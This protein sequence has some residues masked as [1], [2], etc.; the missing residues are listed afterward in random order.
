MYFKS[1]AITRSS[2]EKTP[3]YMHDSFVSFNRVIF[4]CSWF[5]FSIPVSNDWLRPS[6]RRCLVFVFGFCITRYFNRV[7]IKQ[8][9]KDQS[10]LLFLFSVE[11]L[12]LSNVAKS[13]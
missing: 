1:F 11:P 10:V 6:R 2:A 9:C 4:D 3:C 8:L 13:S 5:D 7:F 12:L